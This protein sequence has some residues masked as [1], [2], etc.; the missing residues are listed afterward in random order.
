LVGVTAVRTFATEMTDPGVLK[1]SS[2]K[3]I[4]AWLFSGCILIFCMVVIGGITRLTGSGL[5]IT[6]WNVVMGAIPPLND[7][8]WNE[9][10][11]KY[12]QIP[13]FQ[14][15][16]YHF[17]LDDF[18]KIFFWEYLH[19]LVGRMI[20]LV[21]IIPFLI[22]Y[23]KRM[24]DK[25]LVRKAL[26]LFALGALQGF[27]GWFMVKSGLTEKTSVS[28]IRLAIHLVAAFLTFGFTFW[29]ALDL[30]YRDEKPFVQ[31]KLTT[32]VRGLFALVLLQIIYGAFTAGL[33]AG[34]IAN[35]F[36]T[37]DGQWIPGGLYALSPGYLNFFDNLI[38]VQFIHRCLAMLVVIASFLV[39]FTANN[40]NPGNSQRRGITFL[41]ITIG[42]QF[43]LGVATLLSKVNIPLA[44]MHQAG[45]F[46]VFASSVFLMHRIRR[47]PDSYRD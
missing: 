28:H 13:Q 7:Q 1:T 8:Q 47:S 34:R 9:A 29:Y 26:L 27:L 17:T 21:F 2:V 16:N 45:A 33:H 46:F 18:K 25:N 43:L 42:L 36:P 11:E 12:Q 22:F 44:V 23:F 30:V 35:T 31:E 37:M 38:T 5:S 20:G 3:M 10:F 40:Q 4:T 19:R 41:I 32:L 39:Y 14:K 6:E 15:L 24:L